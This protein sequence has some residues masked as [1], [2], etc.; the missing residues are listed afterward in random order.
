MG[1]GRG[2]GAL[3]IEGG[4]G[5]FDDGRTGAREARLIVVVVVVVVVIVIVIVILL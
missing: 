5:G 3:T 4:E 1:W 2:R